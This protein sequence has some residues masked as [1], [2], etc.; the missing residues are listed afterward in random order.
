MAF[1]RSRRE[2][3]LDTVKATSILALGP[4]LL[5][6][7]SPAHAGNLSNIGPLLAPDAN[8]IRLPSGFTSRVVARS[9][10]AVAGYSW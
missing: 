1:E 4:S 3:L 6:M 7:A 10:Q 2:F 9:G 5:Q 8:G